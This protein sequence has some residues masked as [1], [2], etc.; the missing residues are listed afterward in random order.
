M[1]PAQLTS[2][3]CTSL[4]S[5]GTIFL[6]HSLMKAHLLEKTARSQ[7]ANHNTR[8]EIPSVL[9]SV[10]KAEKNIKKQ[11]RKEVTNYF[12]SL[13]IYKKKKKSIILHLKKITSLSQQKESKLL[14]IVLL[15]RK[16][17]LFRDKH[18]SYQITYAHTC[19]SGQQ[20]K[21]P[22]DVL[23]QSLKIE[24]IHMA[25]QPILPKSCRGSILLSLD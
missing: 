12:T 24:F 13:H 16:K 6:P 8:K 17:S 9:P 2:V 10:K 15:L 18:R 23:L 22:A 11:K 5:D 20:L 1:Q 21:S 25:V 7:Q 14:C 19:T 4:F 3:F